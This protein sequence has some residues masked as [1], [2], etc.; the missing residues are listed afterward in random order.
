LASATELDQ[1]ARTQEDTISFDEKAQRRRSSRK[2]SLIT[3]D[4]TGSDAAPN[5][6]DLNDLAKTIALEKQQ[7]QSD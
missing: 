4:P 1:S 5:R 6:P 2:G 3:Q 7:Q